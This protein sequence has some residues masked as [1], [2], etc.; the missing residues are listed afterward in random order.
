MTVTNPQPTPSGLTELEDALTK[1][2]EAEANL[3]RVITERGWL[4]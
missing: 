1:C 3:R 2:R 4:A